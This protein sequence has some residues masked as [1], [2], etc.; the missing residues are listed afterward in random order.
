MTSLDD[1]LESLRLDII[2]SLQKSG[3]EVQQIKSC[4]DAITAWL[5]IKNRSIFQ[6]PR[7]VTESPEFQNRIIDPKFRISEIKNEFELGMDMTQ[8]LT[9]SYYN[10]N[11]ND[12]LLNNFGIYHL[13][14]GDRDLVK[15]KTKKHLMASGFNDILCAI[16]TNEEVYFLDIVDHDVFKN[17]KMAEGIFR[18]AL[19]SRRDLLSKYIITHGVKKINNSFDQAFQNCRLHHRRKRIGVNSGFELDG[20]CFLTGGV[21]SDRTSVDVR[22]ECDR[23]MYLIID[24]YKFLTNSKSHNLVDFRIT[25]IDIDGDMIT[26]YDKTSK[27][28]ARVI[29]PS[30]MITRMIDADNYE[31]CQI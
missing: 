22:S 24:Q 6:V 28:E 10:A 11:F 26:Y 29:I 31:Y 30:I 25:D 3:F 23:L 7:K 4:A 5:R 21:M 8:R 9:R 27:V 17:S 16:I 20:V 15:D 13:H 2:D 14:L 12:S 19:R 1:L 18:I